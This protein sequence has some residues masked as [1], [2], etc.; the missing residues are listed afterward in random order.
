[1]PNDETHNGW[2]NI[3]TWTVHLWCSNDEQ[4]QL[5]CRELAEDCASDLEA[6]EQI[7]DRWVE[8]LCDSAGPSDGLVC[9]LIRRAL[10]RVDWRRI[11]KAFR[12]A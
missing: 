6:G 8:P 1:M 10:A 11:G 7:R 9:D 4:A 5:S 2:P 3:E 12:E